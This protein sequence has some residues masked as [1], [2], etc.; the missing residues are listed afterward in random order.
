MQ[1]TPQRPLPLHLGGRPVPHPHLTLLCTGPELSRA[2]E[3]I[4]AGRQA[5]RGQGR[6][7]PPPITD[8]PKGKTNAKEATFYSPE[9]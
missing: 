4:T 7:K 3:M 9:S 8:K 5:G 1:V 6:R 2:Q